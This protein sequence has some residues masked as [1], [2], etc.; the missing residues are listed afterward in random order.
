M[1]AL[2]VHWL[3]ILLSAAIVFFISSLVHMA[4][5]WHAADYRGF[6]NED[7]VRDVLRAGA[8]VAGKRFVVPYCSDMKEMAGEA[9]QKKYIDGPN[10]VIVF[11]PNARPN[12]G[13]HLG[14]WFL[15][16]LLVSTVAAFLTAKAYGVAAPAQG[17]AKMAAV[18]AFVAYGFGTIQESIWMY[19]SWSSSA[20]YLLD[21]AL[22]ALGTGAAFYWT[23]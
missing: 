10:A 6:P 4:F 18:V 3:P 9:M 8:P 11:G 2:I 5:K 23:W 17:A 7:A 19:R 16:C 21:S 15:L 12:M 1:N 14:Q 22:Y 13:K 20:K